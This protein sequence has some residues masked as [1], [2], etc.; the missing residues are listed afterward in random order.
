MEIGRHLHDVKSKNTK[1]HGFNADDYLE[2]ARLFFEEKGLDQDL[3]RLAQI[4]AS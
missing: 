4:G 3:T 1:F 2:K